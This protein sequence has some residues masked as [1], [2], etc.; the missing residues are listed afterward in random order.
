MPNHK[1][2]PLRTLKEI[3]REL[4]DILTELAGDRDPMERHDPTTNAMMRV[5]SNELW[6]QALADRLVKDGFVLHEAVEHPIGSGVFEHLYDISVDGV[7][8][9]GR[10]GYAGARKR[11]WWNRRWRTIQIIGVVVNAIVLMAL[12]WLTLRAQVGHPL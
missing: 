4:D 8:H 7:I 12:S 5:R 3:H 9:Y 1:P 2:E 10:G 6:G 11:E